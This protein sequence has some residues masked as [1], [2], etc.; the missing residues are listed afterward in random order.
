MGFS[1]DHV[2]GTISLGDGEAWIRAAD[3]AAGAADG[4]VLA[5][6]GPAGALTW[7]PRDALQIDLSD[8]I[9]GTY[10]DGDLLTF[11]VA[12]QTFVPATP[13]EVV[14]PVVDA[15]LDGLDTLEIVA[16]IA[17]RD[18]LTLGRNA[19]VLVEDASADADVTSGAALYTYKAAADTYTLIATYEDPEV[20]WESI[21][22]RPASSPAQIDGAVALA[23]DHANKA[24]LDALAEVGGA[25]TYSGGLVITAGVI[26]G[27]GSGLTDLDAGALSTGTLPDARLSAAVTASLGLADTAVQP[28]DL[29]DYVINATLAPVAFSGSASDLTTGTL[30]DA[31][32]SG[33]VTASLGLA[34]TAVQPGDLAAVA[35]SGAYTDLSG[36]PTLGTAAATDAADYATAAQGS[37]ADTAVQPADLATYVID[38]DLASVED[39]AYW[40]AATI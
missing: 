6:D 10:D 38:A 4:Y 2:V 17:A 31:R 18:A 14:Q 1:V 3:L 24:L 20:V 11:D 13:Q 40:L 34:D 7:L 28:G 22:G 12:S 32:L 29:A 36:L 23:H 26:T 39:D 8:V 19:L 35:T 21:V 15:A 27:N 33:A 37:L 16:D 9:A 25:L 30:P 5:Y